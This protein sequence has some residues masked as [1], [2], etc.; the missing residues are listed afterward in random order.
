MGKK[1]SPLNLPSLIT[2]QQLTREV[3]S[4]PLVFIDR[5]P[6]VT[7]ILILLPKFNRVSSLMIDNLHV[8]FERDPAKLYFVSCTQVF[9]NFLKVPN[10]TLTFDPMT[11][12]SIGQY[13]YYG[14]V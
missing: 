1:C 5:V 6:N 14:K 4:C 8:K 11:Q 3:T 12:N 2:D 10:L 9:I 7:M 13:V